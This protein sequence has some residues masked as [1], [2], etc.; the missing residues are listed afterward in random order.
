MKNNLHWIAAVCLGMSACHA[1][2]LTPSPADALRQQA[3]ELEAKNSALESQVEELQAQLARQNN[4]PTKAP[5]A[6]LEQATPRA[7]KISIGQL[8]RAL[9]KKEVAGKPTQPEQLVIFVNAQDARGHALQLTGDLTIEASLQSA[10]KVVSLAVA[11]WGPAQ[12]RNAYRAGLGS[13][14]YSLETPIQIPPNMSDA[15]A[16]VVLTYVDGWTGRTLKTER[17][18][19]W[20]IDEFVL[21]KPIQVE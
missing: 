2:V 13:P 6:E 19:P 12:L 21:E 5:S 8:S 15:T 10:G 17:A 20:P 7:A 18:I 3:L 4:S 11:H 9:P 14:H 16:L 1:T